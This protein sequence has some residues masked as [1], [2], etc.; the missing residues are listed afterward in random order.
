MPRAVPFSKFH[1]LS[2][3][4]VVIDALREPALAGLD[5]T[6][7]ARRVCRRHESVGADGV[8][9]VSRDADAHAAMRIVNADGSE[10]GMCGNGLRCVARLLVEG[11]GAAPSLRIRT[12]RGVVG[13]ACEMERGRFIGAT[14][15][16]GEPLLAPADI[17]VRC[18]GPGALNIPAPAELAR[19]C[20]DVGVDE[21][22]TCVSM[23]NPHVV[24][25]C[26]NVEHVPLE[27]LGPRF[28][29]HALFPRRAN[30]QF[31]QVLSRDRARVR[32]WERGA[33]A[34]LAC[35]TGA[36]A[37]AVAGS[38]TGR[39]APDLTVLLPG[40]ELRIQWPGGAATVRM[41]GPAEH[42]FDGHF[43]V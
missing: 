30:V 1:A 10:G 17:P 7:I 20:T 16:M 29:T 11:H 15:E 31:A 43:W 40:G 38:L 25:F 3:D 34:T 42:A 28:E 5:W 39:T 6:G 26:R 9:V 8:L 24:L 27:T 41:T 4:F 18:D 33:G 21:R 22:M 23:G 12:P 2:N 19:A 36:C 32:T 14:V 35:G 13:V 37:V